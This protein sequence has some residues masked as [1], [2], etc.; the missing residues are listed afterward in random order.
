MPDAGYM[1]KQYGRGGILDVI[2]Q[3][4]SA[5]GRNI[6]R[7]KV[8]DLAPVDEFHIRGR[9]ATLELADLA[10]ITPGLRVLDVGSGIG[11]SARFL[12]AE[13][14]C[15]ATGLDLTEEYVQAAAVLTERVGLSDRA[16]FIHGSALSLPFEDASFDLVWTEHAQMNIADKGRF[17]GEIARVLR[18]GGR[19][20]FHDIFKGRGGEIYHPV[21]WA[22]EPSGSFLV[23]AE[24][25]REVMEEAGLEIVAW[26]DKSRQSLEWF[27][28]VLKKVKE[29]GPSPLGLHLLMG[30][31][32]RAKT[33][34]Q[35]RNLEEGRIAVIQGVAEKR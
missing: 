21:P 11:G 15:R 32:A 25:A 28:T 33:H 14:G 1:E 18:P 34:N 3:A 31:S 19:L 10:G 8:C 5:S 26:G 13:R 30:D 16:G 2:F 23:P 27:A 24:E 17:Y 4:L 6:D 12:A 9:E 20:A 7:L 35:I 29:S 22:N